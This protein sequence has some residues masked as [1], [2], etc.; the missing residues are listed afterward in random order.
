MLLIRTGMVVNGRSLLLLH[1]HAFFADIR[2]DGLLVFPEIPGKCRPD[3]EAV[4]TMPKGAGPGSQID[5]NCPMA[6]GFPGYIVH[7]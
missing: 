6:A 1:L 5:G 3:R 4:W 7:N 2:R